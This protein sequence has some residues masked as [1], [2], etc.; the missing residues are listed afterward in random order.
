MFAGRRVRLTR[1][2]F[3]LSVLMGGTLMLAPVPKVM[4]HV[5]SHYAFLFF[6][7]L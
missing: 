2:E 6:G 5:L 4:L 7:L 1:H 3:S